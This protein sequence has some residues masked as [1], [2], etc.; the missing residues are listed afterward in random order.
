MYNI[1]KLYN[2]TGGYSQGLKDFERLKLKNTDQNWVRI[3]SHETAFYANKE[4]KQETEK[5]RFII[6]S[7]PIC[8][9][10]NTLSHLVS[11]LIDIGKMDM[12]KEM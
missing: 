3:A 11:S 7:S 6:L 12:Q 1:F 9:W 8:P 5:R 4:R 2:K 10:I